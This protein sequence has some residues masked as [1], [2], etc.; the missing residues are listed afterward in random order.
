MEIASMQYLLAVFYFI[1][2]YF[3]NVEAMSLL[4]LVP[5]Q[6]KDYKSF[7][8]VICFFI[9]TNGYQIFFLNPHCPNKF[10]RW[11]HK[12]VHWRTLCLCNVLS[13]HCTF[14]VVKYMLSVS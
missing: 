10:S 1:S 9:R 11:R 13:V 14:L 2:K 7:A 12:P 3:L 8:L 5:L 6:C 4:V